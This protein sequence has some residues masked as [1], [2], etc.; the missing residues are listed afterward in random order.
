MLNAVA[1]FGIAQ[2]I[3]SLVLL[4]PMQFQSL[5]LAVALTAYCYF[6]LRIAT[7]I[8]C[9]ADY[10]LA[11]ALR[12]IRL[13]PPSLQIWLGSQLE[14]IPRWVA[15]LGWLLILGTAIY[16]AVGYGLKP[17]TGTPLFQVAG[18]WTRLVLWLWS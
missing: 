11:S 2:L 3:R 13:G 10:M 5:A 16:T 14:R 8:I 12:R 9:F 17:A 18:Y 4:V 7:T 15:L 1:P 6:A